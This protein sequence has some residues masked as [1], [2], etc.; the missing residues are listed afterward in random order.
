MYLPEFEVIEPKTIEEACIE[1]D[2]YK[3][4]G[5]CILAGG[6]DLLVDIRPK[7]IRQHLPR[8]PGC[9]T[10][11]SIVREPKKAPQYVISITRITGI[12][13][14]E[15]EGSWIKIGAMTRIREL[16]E[17]EIIRTHLSALYD[18]AYQLGSPLVR[19]RG[20][21][22]GN[23][24]NARPAADTF[25]PSIALNGTLITASINGRREILLDSFARGPGLTILE[26]G[27]LITHIKFPLYPGNTGSD[28][29]KLANRKALEI[30]IAGVASMVTLNKE[31]NRIESTRIC[32]GA[33]G[34]TPVL[35]KTAMD[36][37][38]GKSPVDDVIHEASRLAVKDA[39]PISDHRG[40]KQY[41]Q[42][43]VEVLTRR[44]LFKALENIKDYKHRKN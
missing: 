4:H 38:A 1:L 29:F 5:V 3:K 43:E 26:P 39:H 23:I 35:A 25:V 44:T 15:I 27:E 9:P 11:G 2:R 40:G 10:D 33:V 16:C 17:S 12:Q 22:G 32:M 37:L 14:I 20:T 7:I 42:I 34:P 18:G 21:I 8:C 41:R 28:Y 13:G 36:F 24:A 30:A 6:T 31:L 19:N